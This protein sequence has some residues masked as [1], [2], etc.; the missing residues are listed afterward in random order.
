[1]IDRKYFFDTVRDSL[2]G[3][4]LTQGQVEGMDAILNEWEAR[5]LADLRWL[6]YMFATTYHETAKTMQPIAEYKLGK[7][8]SYGKPDPITGET[9]YGRG[10]VQ[11]TWKANYKRM[12]DLLKIDLV[13]NPALAMVLKYAVPILFE[14][15]IKGL[16]T[17]KALKHYFTDD[18]NEPV[19]ARKI[20]NGLDKAN[21]I[22]GYHY[23]FL[24]AL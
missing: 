4:E 19:K 15:M 6:A 22:A 17:G 20:I 23:K 16:F 11:L 9:Y 14:G 18:I 24:N 3:G 12:G 13:N 1:M 7:G 5:G 2:F 10:F 21:L 8:R